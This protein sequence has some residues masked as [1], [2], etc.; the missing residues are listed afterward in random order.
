MVLAPEPKVFTSKSKLNI[1]EISCENVLNKQQVNTASHPLPA[2]TR[3]GY[4][5]CYSLFLL[6]RPRARRLG[7]RK[8]ARHR[9]RVN[10]DRGLVL[11]DTRTPAQCGD[12][13]VR[14]YLNND[15]TVSHGQCRIPLYVC[16]CQGI[17]KKDNEKPSH[18]VIFIGEIKQD[19]A[20]IMR[21]CVSPTSQ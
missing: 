2:G 4:M 12:T 7:G 14:G 13:G 20:V 16:T 5:E 8:G 1:Y 15:E 19:C 11:S 17:V 3:C 9:P 18:L 10:G 6:Q 21:L